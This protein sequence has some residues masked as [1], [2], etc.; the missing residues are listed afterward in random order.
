MDKNNWAPRV[1]IAYM[2]TKDQKETVFRAGSGVSY[3]W[4]R[5]VAGAMISECAHQCRGSSYDASKRGFRLLLPQPTLPSSDA[6]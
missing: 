3:F 6:A 4:E 2:L 5:T 1:G